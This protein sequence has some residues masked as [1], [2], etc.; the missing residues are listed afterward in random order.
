MHLV[1]EKIVGW[2]VYTF[3]KLRQLYNWVL[4]WGNSKYGIL[5]LFLFAFI[6]SSFFPI[7]PDVLLMALCL[8]QPS[9][10]FWY[11]FVTTVGSVLGGLF[12][13]FIGYALYETIGKL[14]IAALGY[15]AAFESVGKLF[16]ENAFL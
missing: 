7:P 4:S 1:L 12:G 5:A 10:A 6:E 9:K 15:Q 2:H 16:A 11:A 14:I 8:S 3:G 13:Y